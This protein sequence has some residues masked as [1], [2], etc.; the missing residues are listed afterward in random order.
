MRQSLSP[1]RDAPAPRAEAAPLHSLC[2]LCCQAA[3][4]QAS[5][6]RP[7]SAAWMLLYASAHLFDSVQDGD[8]PDE[9]W[10]ALGSGAAVN[11]AC[12]LL[13]SAWAVLGR[14]RRPWID[15]VRTDFAQT[16]L[17]MGS[18]QHVD[19]TGRRLSLEA[20]WTVAEAKSGAFFAL[21]CRSGARV[22]GAATEEVQHYGRYGMN[23]GLMVQV[24]DDIDDLNS[25]RTVPLAPP[26]PVAYSLET[27]APPDRSR[28]ARALESATERTA[29][30]KLPKLLSHHGVTLYLSTKLAEFRIRGLE[31]LHA[32][33]PQPAAGER[34]AQLIL[35][36]DPSA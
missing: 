19:L 23:L 27:A 18:G 11:V 9:W 17:Q 24:S 7:V 10:S 2:E 35:S 36:L 25:E 12:G 1:G 4:G 21:A 34:L 16:V 3:G 28:L 22:A 32:A 14:V 15:P 29:R 26:L 6:A 5:E 33:A 8:P 30:R 31:A 13:T 20:A